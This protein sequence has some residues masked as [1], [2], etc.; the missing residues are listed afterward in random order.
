MPFSTGLS[1][2]AVLS[3]LPYLDFATF[4]DSLDLFPILHACKPIQQFAQVLPAEGTDARTL[5]TLG[6][7]MNKKRK[8]KRSALMYFNLLTLL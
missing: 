2:E 6:K 4:H 7:Y 1:F 3:P 5:Q 8:V